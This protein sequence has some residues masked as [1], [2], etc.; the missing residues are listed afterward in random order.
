[1]TRIDPP[2]AAERIVKLDALF[3]PY[4]RSDSPGLVVGVAQEGSLLYRRAFGLASLEL[5]IANTTA[6]RMR[7]GSVSKHFTCL[8]ALLLAEEGRLDVDGKIGDILPELPSDQ[9]RPTLRQLMNHTSGLRCYLELG[10]MAGG[11][12]VQ[13]A[14]LALPAQARQ[15]ASNFEPGQYQLYCNG[16]FHLLSIAIERVSGLRFEQFLAERIFAPLGMHNTAAVP[17]DLEVTPHMATLYAHQAEGGWRRA[18]FITEELKGEG[19]IVSTVDDMLLW[20]AHLRRPHTVGRS[21]SWRQMTTPTVLSNGLTSSYGLGLWRMD[22]RGVEVIWH[23]GTVLGGASQML[24]VPEHKLDLII[25]T[26]GAPL[27][28]PVELGKEVI[29]ALLPGALKRP[30]PKRPASRAYRHMLG[31]R[32]H[33]PRGLV[34]GFEEADGVLALTMPGSPIPLLQEERDSLRLAFEETAMG[35]FVFSKS[36]LKPRPAGRPPEFIEISECGRVE[37]YRLLPMKPPSTARIGASLVGR[38][39]SADLNTWAAIAFEEGE[40]VMRLQGGY[41]NLVYDL[42]AASST[43]LYAT[44]RGMTPPVQLPLTVSRTSGQVSSFQLSSGR[45][46]GLHFERMA[47][48]C[49]PLASPS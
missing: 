35:P 43:V 11:L 10:F 6:T 14:G 29:H 26:N 20:L 40:L 46:R 42:T 2:S 45:T 5:G 41:G 38:Y 15:Q 49:K 16:A 18:H 44:V 37:R 22:Y 32:Y 34:I 19:S 17:S 30:P 36:S 7:I 24:S 27:A 13:P 48:E 31:A 3:Q 23:G 39:W 28:R 47:I 1:M 12:A 25:M 9:G 8:A 33:G 4:N 21:S